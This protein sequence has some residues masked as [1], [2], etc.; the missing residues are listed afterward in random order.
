MTDKTLRFV[1]FLLDTTIYFALLIGFLLIF[2]NQID[3]K[4]VK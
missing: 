3:E 2:K 4:Y 1:N